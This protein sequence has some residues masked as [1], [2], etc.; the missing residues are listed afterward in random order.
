MRALV[1][2]TGLEAVA[3]T[4]IQMT[5]AA[6]FL[7]GHANAAETHQYSKELLD[8][9]NYPV[10]TFFPKQLLAGSNTVIPYMNDYFSNISG[11]FLFTAMENKVIPFM[12]RECYRLLYKNGTL[13]IMVMDPRPV[14]DSLGPKLSAWL[15]TNL[16]QYLEDAD[17]DSYSYML[18][19][20]LT[21]NGFEYS[22]LGGIRIDAFAI[23]RHDQLH[24]E[25]VTEVGRALWK[26]NFGTWTRCIDGKW[27]WEHEDILE[28]CREMN[29][30]W[31]IQLI[32]CP[33]VEDKKYAHPWLT[34]ASV[35]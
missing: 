2:G 11:A 30:R 21:G 5:A 18:P 32:E 12:I 31:S 13:S 19:Q 34:F 22:T 23:P 26:K 33:K 17:R 6:A 16:I 3:F 15:Q 1:S 28:E 8:Q 35:S 10:H 14:R 29:T 7:A 27:W 20:W 9:A 25:L 4:N 24:R